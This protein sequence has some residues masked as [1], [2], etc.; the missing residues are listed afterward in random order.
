MP[1][2]RATQKPGSAPRAGRK[3]SAT[4]VSATRA[5]ASNKGAAPKEVAAKKATAQSSKGAHRREA[6]VLSRTSSM[7]KDI[8]ARGEE[9]TSEI[10]E[11]LLRLR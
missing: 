3:V 4:K 6:V 5:S 10:N 9:L 7:L 2:R 1:D 8:R 11:L